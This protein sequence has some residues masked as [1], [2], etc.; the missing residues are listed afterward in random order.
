MKSDEKTLE[1]LK[2]FE[3]IGLVIPH[4]KKTHAEHATGIMVFLGFR[5]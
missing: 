3:A 1:K 5:C 4:W 2:Y